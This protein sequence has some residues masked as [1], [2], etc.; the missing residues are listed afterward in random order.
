[1]TL[2]DRVILIEDHAVALDEPVA[3]VRPRSHGD[4]AFAAL[5]ARVLQ[6][7]LGHGPATAAVG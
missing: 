2:A 5:E 1:V 6:R 3:L 7:V 4:A